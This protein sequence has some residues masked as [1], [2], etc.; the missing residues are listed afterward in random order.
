M[1]ATKIWFQ[2]N[3]SLTYSLDENKAQART[4]MQ[5]LSETSTKP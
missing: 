5:V 2:A 3:F 1:P 4:F